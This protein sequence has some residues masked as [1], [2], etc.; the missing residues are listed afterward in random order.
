[1]IKYASVD[2]HT[3]KKALT[4]NDQEENPQE[5]EDNLQGENANDSSKTNVST[6]K[7]YG[8]FFLALLVLVSVTCGSFTNTTPSNQDLRPEDSTMTTT[9][10]EVTLSVSGNPN[11]RGRGAA[12]TLGTIP[13]RPVTSPPTK[14]P[15][16]SPTKQPTSSPT[17]YPTVSPTS[18]PT[19]SPTSY[20]TSSPT[21]YPTSSP[22]SQPTSP[23]LTVLSSMPVIG[24]GI[25]L[26]ILLAFIIKKCCCSSSDYEQI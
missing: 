18:Q 10:E 3:L 26:L 13:A 1:M 25:G 20:P 15:T 7:R 4:F 6:V 14:Q 22:T 5:E 12:V 8:V 19:S 16:S 24:V 2:L 9:R 23:P 11:V 21:S 17:S